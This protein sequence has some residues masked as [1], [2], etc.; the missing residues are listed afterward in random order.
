MNLAE[1]SALTEEEARDYL[2]SIRWPN[3][4]ICPHC[5]V[6]GGAYKLQGKSTRP[7]TYKCSDCRKPFTVTVGTI[8]H[9]SRVGLRKWLM[10]FALVCS[11]KKG[12]SALQLQRN[13]GLGSYQTA[14]HMAHRIR[15]AMTQEPLAGMLK[16][17][18]EV[19]EAYVEGKRRKGAPKQT[20]LER[21]R[22]V[23]VAVERDGNAYAFPCSRVTAERLRPAMQ[24]LIDSEA[25]VYT[26]EARVYKDWTGEVFA[27]HDTTNHASGE[28]LR[29]GVNSNTAESYFALLK[30][31]IHGSFH[32]VSWKHLPRYCSEFSFRW[33]W[34]KGS[35]G[36]RTNAALRSST[37]KRLTYGALV[38]RTEHICD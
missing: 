28:Y 15:H 3:G 9:G 26:D 6:E 12:I 36:E 24:L 35:D 16:G 11:S 18:V 31:G 20:R 29:G 8:F 19:D 38:G 22:P 4:P 27:R 23:V 7:G 14:W 10:A 37:G 32:H 25:T 1:I 5:G 21:Q 30:R 2:E 33:N 34:R 13:L 17:T